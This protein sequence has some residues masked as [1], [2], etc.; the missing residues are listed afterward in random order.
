MHLKTNM[1]LT[2]VGVALIL[3]SAGDFLFSPEGPWNVT[4][5]IWVALLS[6]FA[7]FINRHAGRVWLRQ[8]L[9]WSAIAI[10]TA[11]LLAIRDYEALIPLV[12]LVQAVCATAVLM[13]ADNKRLIAA[14]VETFLIALF[15]LP[16]QMVTRFCRLIGNL[17]FF[18]MA[19]SPR[20]KGVLRGLLI[21]APLLVVFT[22]LFSSADANFERYTL[23]LG[24]LV[25]V[26]LPQHVLSI[27]LL[28]AFSAGLLLCTV[29]ELSNQSR[30]QARLLQNRINFLRSLGDE[31]I[32]VIMGSLV[33]LFLVFVLLQFGYLFG[34]RETIEQVDGLT[35]A[36]YARRGFFELI[37]VSFLT[38]A[39][40]LWI[41]S[42]Q[43]SL[44]IFRPM[45]AVLVVCVLF[46]LVS[47]AQRLYLYSETFGLTLSRVLAAAI[48]LWLAGNLVSFIVT[49]L[50]S[51]GAGFAFGMIVSGIATVILLGLANPA[52]IVVRVNLNNAIE[53]SQEETIDIRYLTRL[54]ADAVPALLERIHHLPANQQCIVA[55]ELITRYGGERNEDD[56]ND[57]RT[58]NASRSK[59]EALV[60]QHYKGRGNFA[61]QRVALSAVKAC[62]V[63]YRWQPVIP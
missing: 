19:R 44:R 3:G 38:L 16:V 37:A 39:V 20:L 41:S 24:D 29:P 21:V 52:A 45:A 48:M 27:A 36:T 54:G 22:M 18:E 32:T 8:L 42:T 49:L 12:L 25:S 35:L 50:R 10:A 2:I 56:K 15:A 46:I 9:T 61:G 43:C 34:G 28:S 23:A 4:G 60:A 14:R 58:W 1:M 40:L 7:L 11:M 33:L 51:G 17:P 47:A 5:S 30:L 57:W 55:N 59:A 53:S 62:S 13:Q 63:G 26:E 6:L 31:E